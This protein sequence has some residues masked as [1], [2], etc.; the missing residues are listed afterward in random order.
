MDTVKLIGLDFGTTTSS[1]VIASA[2]LLPNAATG[3]TEPGNLR[4]CYRSEIVFTPYSGNSLDLTR[5][6]EYLDAWLTAGA[7]RAEEIFGGGALLTGLAAQKDNAPALVN[8]IRQRVADALIASADDPSLE[9]WLAFM[10]SCA[11]LSRDHPETRFV[12]LDIGGG[13]TNLALG[14]NGEVLS[15]GCLYLGARH[16]KVVPGTYRIVELS[17]YARR[18]LQHLGIDKDQGAELVRHEVEAV[19]DFYVLL[20]EAALTGRHSVFEE[21]VARLHQQVAF[22]PEPLSGNADQVVVTLS[23]GVGE[24]VYAAVQGEAR[25]PTTYFGDLG[26]DL[27]ARL[28]DA[29][30]WS[31]HFRH[32]RPAGKGRA[33]VYGLLRHSTQV[34]GSTL[35]LPDASFLPLR[36][37][38]IL[39]TITRTTSES[40]LRDLLD[41]VQRSSTGGCLQ[42]RLSERGP[43]SVRQVGTRIAREL[44]ARGFPASQPLVFLVAE[45]L[46]KALGQYI[47]QWGAL[48]LKFAVLDEINIPDAQYVHLGRLHNHVIPVSFHGIQA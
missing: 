4:E 45:N 37:L 18:L 34:S 21:P 47:S 30:P 29:S 46:G 13:T 23:G 28:L 8:L 9:S 31:A 43:A 24:L 19:L 5:L 20:L 25:Q 11:R 16:I 7:V 17:P 36:N 39:G 33:T 6:S 12:N 15:T 3:R 40:Q 35:F 22:K 26:I 2:E 14:R 38:P 32:Y 10:G 42:I 1:A 41:M 27:A 48:P 44:K